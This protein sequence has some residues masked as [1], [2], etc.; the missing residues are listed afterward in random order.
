MPL[1]ITKTTVLRSSNISPFRDSAG[2]DPAVATSVGNVARALRAHPAL[3]QRSI[4]I[5]N[6]GLTRTTTT[7]WD[8]RGAYGE[9]ALANAAD[10]GRIASAA[11]AYNQAN[12]ITVTTLIK[13]D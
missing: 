9:F 10:L 1:T 2:L 7:V 6:D 8:N 11:S 5:S 3:R 13:E 12:G 4:S